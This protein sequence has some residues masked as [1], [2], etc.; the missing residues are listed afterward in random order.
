[1][2]ILHTHTLLHHL[3]FV[4]DNTTDQQHKLKRRS[5]ST[6]EA[7]SNR[8]CSLSTF[9][10]GKRVKVSII[11]L[12][13][14]KVMNLWRQKRNFASNPCCLFVGFTEFLYYAFRPSS[15][16][17]R[18][19]PKMRSLKCALEWKR[20]RFIRCHLFHLNCNSNECESDQCTLVIVCLLLSFWKLSR[21][22]HHQEATGKPWES[23]NYFR[24]FANAR[25][26]PGE[27]AEEEE[28]ARAYREVSS[29]KVHNLPANCVN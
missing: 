18:R 24:T 2:P 1:M 6:K 23:V 10:A 12:N 19:I 17:M 4:S 5:K 14:W 20:G 16:N 11:A 9:L 26:N 21:L 15:V 3:L 8:S 13:R 28:V 25:L 7:F 22:F 27:F 29:E